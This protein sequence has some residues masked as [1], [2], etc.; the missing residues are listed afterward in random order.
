MANKHSSTT[1]EAFIPT[2]IQK[3]I[4]RDNIVTPKVCDESQQYA[5]LQQQQQF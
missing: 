4:S 3:R 2:T 5:K 1:S